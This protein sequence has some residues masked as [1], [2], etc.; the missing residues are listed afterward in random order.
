MDTNSTDTT[1]ASLVPFPAEHLAK[2]I[3][4]EEGETAIGRASS[5]TIQLTQ[6]GVSRSHARISF[7]NGQYILTDLGS[8]NGTFVNKERVKQVVLS[9]NDKILFGK[10]G[11]VFL[12]GGTDLENTSVDFD[13]EFGDTVAISE[14][15]LELAKL[16]TCNADEAAQLFLEPPSIEKNQAEL[17]ALAQKRLSILY[18]LSEKLRSAKE[19]N[20]ILDQGLELIFKALPSAKRGVVMLRSDTTGA[21]EARTVKYR[22]QDP[23]EGTIPISRTVLDQAVENQLAMVSRDIQDDARFKDSDSIV[24]H[25]I[26]SII[27]VPLLSHSKVIG[28]IHVDTDD[29]LNP[30]TKNDMEFTA[31]VS[32]ELALCIENCRLRKHTINNEKMAAI[33]LTITNVAHN[34]KNLFTVSVNSVDLMDNQ[35]KTINDKEIHE[36]WRFVRESLEKIANLTA[37]MLEYTQIDSHEPQRVNVNAAIMA[38]CEVFKTDLDQD[39][40]KLELNLAPDLPRWVVNET[41]LQRAIRNLVVNAKHALKKIENGCIKIS[42]E[43]DELHRLFIRTTDN[44]CGIDKDNLNKIFD[45]FYTTKGMD[46]SGLGLASVK[47]FVESSGGKI[48]VVS[49]VGV[50]SVFSMVFPETC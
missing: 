36:C 47:K 20:E 4:L 11:F 45:L 22:S 21:L 7:E 31:A 10:R 48:S 39:G 35:L 29:Y 26:Q 25:N 12:N 33:G 43:L 37:D 19:S 3:Q 46:G 34:I 1:C 24:I 50:G 41:E 40:I 23:E 30:F 27:C 44:G 49:Q 5:N 17:T 18:Q 2:P 38:E 14:E 32:N 9:H 42:S 15:D 6:G 8:R 16:L 13:S 28:A